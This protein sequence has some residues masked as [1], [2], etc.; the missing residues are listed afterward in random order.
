[1][2]IS[3]LPQRHDKLKH[4]QMQFPRNIFKKKKAKVAS[5]CNEAA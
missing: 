4:L 2:F 3:V 5:L 1:V